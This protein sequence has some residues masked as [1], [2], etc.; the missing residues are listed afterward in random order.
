MKYEEI[1]DTLHKKLENI[2]MCV[3]PLAIP[4]NNS[5]SILKEIESVMKTF[6]RKVESNIFSQELNRQV[7]ILLFLNQIKLSF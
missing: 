5:L 1:S 3:S 7:R 4:G 2:L 6:M